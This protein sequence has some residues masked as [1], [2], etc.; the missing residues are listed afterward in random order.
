MGAYNFLFACLLSSL[1]GMQ[2]NCSIICVLVLGF[3]LLTLLSAKKT[4]NMQMETG[5]IFSYTNNYYVLSNIYKIR[6]ITHS[7]CKKFAYYLSNQL[8]VITFG[9]NI[10]CKKSLQCNFAKFQLDKKDILL[11]NSFLYHVNNDKSYYS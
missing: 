3:H 11:R 6:F 2:N 1:P 8:L 5:N 10:N 7:H 9:N 4:T